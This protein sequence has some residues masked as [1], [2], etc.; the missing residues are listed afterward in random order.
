MIYVSFIITLTEVTIG[1]ASHEQ[2]NRVALGT[3]RVGRVMTR[4]LNL[5][6]LDS[7]KIVQKNQITKLSHDSVVQYYAV[8]RSVFGVE[9]GRAKWL[10]AFIVLMFRI[11]GQ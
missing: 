4:V 2:S 3:V 8:I 11:I 5:T 6:K 9:A 10:N 1:C 7:F